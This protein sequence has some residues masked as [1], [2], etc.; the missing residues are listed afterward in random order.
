MRMFRHRMIAAVERQ[1]DMLSQET[2]EPKSQEVSA[3]QPPAY[4]PSVLALRHG[5]C[6][7]SSAITYRSWRQAMPVTSSRDHL[8]VIHRSS[9]AARRRWRPGCALR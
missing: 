1:L 2:E 3:D 9:A 4:G 8:K 7:Y 6:G 5:S